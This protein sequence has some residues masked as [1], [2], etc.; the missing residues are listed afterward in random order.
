[1]LRIYKFYVNGIYKK[2][3]FILNFHFTHRYTCKNHLNDSK[4]IL[5]IIEQAYNYNKKIEN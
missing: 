4:L 5:Q 1:M 2:S 3:T